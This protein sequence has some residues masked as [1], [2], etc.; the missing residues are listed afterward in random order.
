MRAKEELTAAN[1][2][3]QATYERRLKEPLQSER[4]R[5][6]PGNKKPRHRLQA[7]KPL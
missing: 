2:R 6:R 5:W 4:R 3:T 7:Y 1:V